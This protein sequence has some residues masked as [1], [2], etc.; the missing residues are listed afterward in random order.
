VIRRKIEGLIA[1]PFTLPQYFMQ[2]GY[3]AASIGK[4]FHN[5]GQAL[6]GDPGS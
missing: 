3:H 1:A 5:W 6:Q 2:H 4:V